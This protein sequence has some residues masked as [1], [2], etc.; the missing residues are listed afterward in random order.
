MLGLVPYIQ[1]N[2]TWNGRF[3]NDEVRDIKRGVCCW[4]IGAADRHEDK[5]SARGTNV[6]VETSHTDLEVRAEEG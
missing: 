3:L 2:I 1:P 6:G 4:R 5:T